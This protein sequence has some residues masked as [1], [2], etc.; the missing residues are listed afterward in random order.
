MIAFLAQFFLSKEGIFPRRVGEE[1]QWNLV[2]KEHSFIHSFIWLNN[3][4]LGD[5]TTEVTVLLDLQSLGGHSSQSR[6]TAQPSGRE[7]TRGSVGRLNRDWRKR[8]SWPHK[9][10]GEDWERAPG[11]GCG[12]RMGQGLGQGLFCPSLMEEATEAQLHKQFGM[13]AS[14]V[15]S[16]GQTQTPA[17]WS[18]PE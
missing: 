6:G 8:R 1:G 9:I 18:V 11:G 13:E 10:K 16:T 17:P 2:Y 4:D 5:G 3:N 7:E 14:L 15:G 12:R